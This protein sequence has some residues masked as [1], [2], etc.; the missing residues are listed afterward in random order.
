MATTGDANV[1]ASGR[2]TLDSLRVLDFGDR[3]S[4]AWCA[5]LMADL[6]A[7]VIGAEP[8][9][10]H[11]VRSDPPV[12]AYVLANRRRVDL[13]TAFSLVVEAE[14]ILTSE[15]TPETKVGALRQLSGS[16]LIVSI[17]P[18]G[19][20][21]TR[22][23]QPGNDLTAYATSGWA[24]VNGLASLAPLKGTGYNA[25]YQT[26]HLCLGCG[27]GNPA[28]RAGRR[29]TRH[30]RARRAVLH[31]FPGVPSPAVHRHTGG[32]PEGRRHHR[33]TGSRG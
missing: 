22:S 9:E 25:S 30:R 29:S 17:T 3:A 27:H 14:V 28:R 4:T 24:S 32:S 20:S 23:D 7:D 16:A 6:G 15:S 8:P 1:T 10:G 5:R 21:S 13:P 26:G 11:P 2:A 12:A 18:Y 19:L 33:R 31:A